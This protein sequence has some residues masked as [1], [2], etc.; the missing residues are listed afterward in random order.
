MNKIYFIFDFTHDVQ[1]LFDLDKKYKYRGFP[2]KRKLHRK[3]QTTN[4]FLHFVL[5]SCSSHHYA[6]LYAFW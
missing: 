5:Q 3:R 2:A 1:F 6:L 4:I